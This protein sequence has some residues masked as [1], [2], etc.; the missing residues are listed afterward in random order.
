[1]CEYLMHFKRFFVQVT[2]QLKILTTAIFSVIILRRKLLTTQWGA[3]FLLLCGVIL[4][5]LAQ[6]EEHSTTVTENGQQNH[7]VGIAAAVAAC[8]LSGFA[9]IY[10]EKI[11]KGSSLSIW[12]R[13]VQLSLC[14]IPFAA[15][16][17]YLND[18]EDLLAKGYFYG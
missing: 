5:E 7:V 16:T 18:G 9:G 13:N 6:S 8:C 3:L 15:I 4:V 2:Y 1:M 12:I 11:L 14:S 10:F 17:S